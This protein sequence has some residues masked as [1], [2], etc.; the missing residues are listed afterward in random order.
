[1]S[2]NS[3][4]QAADLHPEADLGKAYDA[5]LIR[6]LWV[7]VRPYQKYFWAALL[8]LPLTSALSLAQPY[9]LKVAIDQNI[10]SQ[11]GYG[12]ART[13]VWYS[14]AMV[15]EFSLLYLQYYLTMLVAQKS[16]AGLR[17][18]LVEH[19]QRLPARFF[20]RNPVG[21]LVTRL[22][23]DVDAI[24]EMFAVGGLTILMDVVTLLGIV[25]IMLAIDFRLALVT[26]T[27]APIL[28]LAI[29]FFRL[30]ARQN[31]RLIRD[32]LARLNAFLQEALAGMT[33]VQLF[34]RERRMWGRFDDLNDSYREANH[35]SNIY[36]AT[37]FSLVETMSAISFA[38]IVWYGGG[39]I[40]KGALAFGT[41]VAFIEYIQKFF[42]PIRDFSTKY[43]VMQSAMSSAERVF[44]LLDTPADIAS[45]SRPFVPQRV[46][47][48]IEFDG[49]WF[50]YRGDDYVLRDL[51][52]TVEPGEKIAF[53]G[54]TGSGKTTIM[55]L[56]NRSYDVD[57]GRVLVDDVDVRDWD[58]T[59]L[60]R[61]I[62]VVLQDVFLFSGTIASNLT[63][64]S[65][66]VSNEA[67]IRA[68]HTVH[69]DLFVE[70][71]PRRYDEP[72]RERGNNL[73][74]GQR[75]LLSFARALAYEPAI[76]VLDE[77]TSSVDT[78]TEIL[79]QD[80]LLKLLQ[81]RTAIVIA[82]RLS[83]IEHADRILVVHG[84]ELRESGTH[85][86]LLENRG[87]YYRLY[88]LQYVKGVT[89]TLPAE[90]ATAVT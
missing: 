64:E 89:P 7:Y 79:I 78:E 4:P 30:R 53:V 77:A 87:V 13:A 3:A 82:H 57:R 41:L 2:G 47:G 31:Y 75:Q 51:S 19:V 10:A 11:D 26:L 48:K 18:D 21:R 85:A 34:A 35:A 52:F 22:T 12:L 90:A 6:R 40:L 20:D 39:Q 70:K 37:L 27:V 84:G 17:R 44:Q 62:G 67:A 76:L 83:T 61:H 50:A 86:E 80:A 15:G 23:T 88:Q 43:A 63:L 28:V 32:R 46:C 65:P 14:L 24:N 72:V 36:E 9:L 60:R 45:P 25:G 42:V 38:L 55:K 1:V 8:C 58:L 68:A 33:V 49:V 71:L 59:A 69:A 56:L 16:L 29:N 81:G 54:P 66:H 74:T 73:S 5:R